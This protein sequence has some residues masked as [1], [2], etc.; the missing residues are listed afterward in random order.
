MS[1]LWAAAQPP[2]NRFPMRLILASASDRRKELLRSAGF[3][4][5]VRASDV[6]ETRHAGESA[7]DYTRRIARAKARAVGASAPPGSVI[8]GADTVVVT[9]GEILGKPAGPDDAARMLRQLSG[10]THRVITA[11]CVLHPPQGAED[12]KL[13]V[14]WV[15]FAPLSEQEIHDYVQSGEPMDKAGAYAI[16]GLASKFVTQI[17]GSYSNVVGLPIHL[18]YEMLKPFGG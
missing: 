6:D 18:V 16:Q 8:L 5:E 1:V 17:Q 2:Y 10:Y 15:T 11:V 4:F 9:D 3:G 14:T 12:L 13:A 7:E